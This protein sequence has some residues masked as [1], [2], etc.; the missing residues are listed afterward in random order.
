MRSPLS[1]QTSATTMT[2]LL[3]LAAA[4]QRFCIAV[5]S[6]A[7]PFLVVQ[8]TVSMRWPNSQGMKYVYVPAMLPTLVS[9]R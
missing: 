4:K 1:Q 9:L 6:H 5:V 2:G 7:F 3:S 8:D